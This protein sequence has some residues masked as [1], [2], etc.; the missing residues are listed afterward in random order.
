MHARKRLYRVSKGGDVCVWIMNEQ[1]G[2]CKQRCGKRSRNAIVTFRDE[3]RNSVNIRYLKCTQCERHAEIT[4][5]V[6]A[7]HYQAQ[8]R[9]GNAQTYATVHLEETAQVRN[10]LFRN[11]CVRKQHR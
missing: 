9:I 4:M 5:R 10:V 7:R 1:C 11:V 6:S 2:V 3:R 8:M